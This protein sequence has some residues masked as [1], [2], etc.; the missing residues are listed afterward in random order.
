MRNSYLLW[1]ICVG[2]TVSG[3]PT[4]GGPPGTPREEIDAMVMVADVI[5]DT[6]ALPDVSGD[7]VVDVKPE[8]D[9]VPIQC[10]DGMSLC[11]STPFNNE[12]RSSYRCRAPVSGACP[13]P[14]LV[15]GRAWIFDPDRNQRLY[16]TEETFATDAAELNE[17]CITAPGTRRLLRFNFAAFNRGNENLNV[18]RP[19]EA[20]PTHWEFFSAHGHWH[21][22]GWGD[23]KLRR[24]DGVVVG[25]GRKLSFCL[26]DNIREND[27]AGPRQFAPPLC[28]RFDPRSSYSE[29]PEFGLSVGWG[30]IYPHDVRCQ[31]I[32]LGPPA[33]TSP[34]YLRDDF[35]DLILAINIGDRTSAPLYRESNYSNNSETYRVEIRQGEATVCTSNAG[36]ACPVGHYNC[37]GACVAQ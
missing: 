34:G 14:D 2:S 37:A 25:R 32:D 20:D 13:A 15:V 23:L 8:D 3:C 36:D 17:G 11:P 26:E 12:R 21:V 19:N 28:A 16:L 27:M 1:M 10:P 22:K 29:R 24:L 30:D 7:T 35:Y 31:F 18:G 9:V 33:P 6:T 4:R 5:P